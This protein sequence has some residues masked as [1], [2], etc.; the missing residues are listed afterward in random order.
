VFFEGI[1]NLFLV[2]HELLLLI[3]DENS[4][5]D[6][7]DEGRG[8][9]LP[10]VVVFWESVF[11][12]ERVSL[13][14]GTERHLDVKSGWVSLCGLHPKYMILAVILTPS[15]TFSL[16]KLHPFIYLNI[17]TGLLFRINTFNKFV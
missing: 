13:K 8:V 11:G 17:V 1:S 4:L 2:V 15:L 12:R 9:V 16:L 3:F 10:I 6:T 14:F 5:V 7:E